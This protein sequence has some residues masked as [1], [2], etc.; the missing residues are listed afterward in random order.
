[1]LTLQEVKNYLRVDFE[2]DDALL[3]SLMVAADEYL[4]ASVGAS[5]DA[6]SERAKILSLIVVSD[7]Y[8][9]REATEKESA[10]IRQIVESFSLQMR[11]ELRP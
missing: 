1:M 2:N 7:M 9:N 11:L 8:S 4:K 5:Y 6:E 10:K 3:T